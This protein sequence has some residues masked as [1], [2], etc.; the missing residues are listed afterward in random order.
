[1]FQGY[2]QE[3]FAE[4]METERP[5]SH[6]AAVKKGG[7]KKTKE[8]QPAEPAEPGGPQSLSHLFDGGVVCASLCFDRVK[9]MCSSLHA[10]KATPNPI[11]LSETQ[12]ESEYVFASFPHFPPP[13]LTPANFL[14]QGLVRLNC[15]PQ[16][17]HELEKACGARGGEVG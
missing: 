6:A 4:K 7:R 14:R 10:P 11:I 12:L 8:P 1:M 3:P 17:Q 5:G 9:F 16:L 15:S 13:S 2:V